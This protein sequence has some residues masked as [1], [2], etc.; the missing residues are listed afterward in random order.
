[1]N[2]RRAI[3]LAVVLPIV[4]VFGLAASKCSDQRPQRTDAQIKADQLITG[5][6]RTRLTE[7]PLVRAID[8]DI[9]TSD[10]KVTLGGV[11]ESEASKAE[12]VRIASGVEVTVDGQTFKVREVDASKV[13]LKPR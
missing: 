1:M 11:T 6:V 5:E 2:R 3:L 4:S 8:L 12:A 10:L 13:T 7:S 9:D